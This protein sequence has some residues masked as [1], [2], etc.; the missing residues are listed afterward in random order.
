MGAKTSGAASEG[1]VP[2]DEV[3]APK[4]VGPSVRP[5]APRRGRVLVVDDE[6]AVGRTIHRMLSD[7]H[8]VI[9]LT[10]GSQA[11]EVLTRGDDFDLILCDI[12]MPD[13]TG[14]EVYSRSTASRP[15]LI[16]RFVFMTGG[17]FTAASRTF[18]ETVDR[19]YLEKPFDLE[20]L[21]GIVQSRIAQTTR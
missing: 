18:L 20:T 11:L 4:R 10:G 21:R 5:V 6:L 12:S 17:S 14:I 15:E 3:I 8:D 9:V 19:R 13:V 16:D 2:A 1:R 7:R